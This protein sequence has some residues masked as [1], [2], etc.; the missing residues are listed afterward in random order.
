METISAM[1]LRHPSG[2]PEPE[3]KTAGETPEFRC[4]TGSSFRRGLM[5][6]NP[7]DARD[8]RRNER[9]YCAQRLTISS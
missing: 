5:K 3:Q 9:A 2:K 8:I 7:A 1:N 4:S 6:K